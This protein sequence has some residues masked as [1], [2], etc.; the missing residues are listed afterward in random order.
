MN[1]LTTPAIRNKPRRVV[2]NALIVTA[3]FILLAVAA[4]YTLD[5]MNGGYAAIVGCGFVALTSLITALVYVPR[6]KEFDRLVN[7]LQPLAHWT[8]GEDEWKAFAEVDRKENAA[9]NK[10]VLLLLIVISVIVCGGLAFLYKDR[11]FLYLLAGIIVFYSIVAAITPYLR[12]QALNNGTR[13]VIISEE[14]I[15]VGGTFQTWKHLG[16]RLRN[17]VVSSDGPVPMLQL[18]IDFPT[19]TGYEENVIRAPIPPGKME[20]A[21][22]V[23][24]LLARQVE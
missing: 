24:L 5:G 9:S 14:A 6:A 2:R 16:A 22:K 13:E 15:L 20:E 19:R 1:K 7:Q 23:Q 4:G 12:K 8:I 3:V 18:L 17:V 10:A 11:F 21:V